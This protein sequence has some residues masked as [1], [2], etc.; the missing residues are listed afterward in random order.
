LISLRFNISSGGG[1]GARLP[2]GLPKISS[3][4]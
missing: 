3:I 1:L 2:I 4:M